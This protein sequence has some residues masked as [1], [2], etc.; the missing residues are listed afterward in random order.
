M[1][2]NVERD[3]VNYLFFELNKQ[4]FIV[5]YEI[6]EYDVQYHT[7]VF[8]K[9]KFKN[10]YNKVKREKN[11]TDHTIECYYTNTLDKEIQI[12]LKTFIKS[13]ESLSLDKIYSDLY[14]LSKSMSS[15][16]ECYFLLVVKESH[17]NKITEKNKSFI[18]CLNSYQKKYTF[19][20][21]NKEIDTSI[22][23]SFK[24]SYLVKEKT[25]NNFSDSY[26]NKYHRNQIRIFLFKLL[27]QT[28]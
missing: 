12:E 6:F 5:D 11:K 1:D 24:T 18:E 23:R 25:A 2:K 16:N 13:K 22:I 26:I 10:T 28:R 7:H 14:K 4:V 15:N 27:N 21:N 17:L 20:I 19:S 9:N 3:L 8:L